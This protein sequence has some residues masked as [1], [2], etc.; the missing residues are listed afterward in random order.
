MIKMIAGVGIVLALS[1]CSSSKDLECPMGVGMACASMNQ[2]SNAL[3][4][5]D[6]QSF[7]KSTETVDIYV[8][9]SDSY[10]SSALL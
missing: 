5:K 4:E 6:H 1:G 3:D 10:V 9:A 2:V 8:V 7:L